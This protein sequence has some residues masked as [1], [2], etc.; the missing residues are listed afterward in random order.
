MMLKVGYPLTTNDV[1][2]EFALIFLAGIFVLWITWHKIFAYSPEK[3]YRIN[4][5]T[6]VAEE[7][8]MLT[9]PPLPEAG[10]LIIWN[11]LGKV[12]RK[13]FILEKW[14]RN[15]DVDIKAYIEEERLK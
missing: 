10:G 4:R 11:P 1:L 5:Y 2:I 7:Q 9:Y 14:A 12:T 13:Q 8:K 15:N 3:R 6:G